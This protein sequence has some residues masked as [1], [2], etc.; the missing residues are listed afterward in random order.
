MWRLYIAVNYI[1]VFEKYILESNS[2]KLIK[3]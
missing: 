2:S 1:D 3:N